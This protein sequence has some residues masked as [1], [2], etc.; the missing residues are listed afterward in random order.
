M[1]KTSECLVDT[2]LHFD[3]VGDFDSDREI[4][5]A[6]LNRL[7]KK[8]RSKGYSE[9]SVRLGFGYYEGEEHL[10]LWGKK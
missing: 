10:E 2:S 6:K 8:F 3:L 4:S 5:L 9:F 1:A 7:A